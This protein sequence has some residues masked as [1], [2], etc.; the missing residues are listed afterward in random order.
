[1]KNKHFLLLILTLFA[2]NTNAQ[3]FT[4]RPV[5]CAME[6][7]WEITYGP[8]NAIW[9][10]EARGYRVSRINPQTGATNVLL[11]LTNSK[12]FPNYPTVSPQGGL[13]GLALHPNLLTGK[14]YVYLAYVYRYDGGAA[15]TGQFFKT[16]VVRYTYNA[17]AQ[18]LS[19]EEVMCDTIPGS[20]DH[21][22]GRMT[23]ANI[24][25]APYLFYGVGDMG[26]GQFDNANRLNK[27]QDATS[28]EGKILRFNVEPDAD[29]NA[30]EKWIPNDGGNAFGRA[31][32]SIGHRNPQGL[33]AGLNG[34]IYQAEHGPYSDDELNLLNG[35][36]RNYGH[37]LVV[38]TADGNYN[39]AAVG[40][41]TGVPLIANEINNAASLG[42]NYKNPLKSFFPVDNQTIRSIYQN[43][44]NGT[45]PVN[46]YFLSW[47]S[48]APSGIDYYN[49]TA[50]PN[51]Q[52][53]I[54]VTSLKRRRVYR[55]QL[56]AAGTAV[57]G[58]TIPLFA[59]MG[60]FRDVC[61]SPDGTKIYV[62]CD[63]EGQTSGPTAGTTIDP[64]NK[65]CILEFTYAPIVQNCVF[66]NC[67]TNQTFNI[68]SGTTQVVNWTAPTLSNCN[69]NTTI[70][71]NYASGNAFSVGTTTVTYT[72]TSGGVTV[73]TCSFSITV[74][75]AQTG[76]YCASKSTIP[77]NEWISN[78]SL[79]TL[80]N[81]SEKTRSD[82]YVVGYSDWTDKSTALS[83][84][85]NYPL[86][87]TPSLNYPTYPTNLFTR[88][89]IDFNQ[90]K[91][92]ED[93]EIVLSQNN[94]NQI[95]TQT[96]TVPASA[97]SGTTVMRVSMKAGAY[98]TACETFQNGE[99]EDYSVVIGASS[100]CIAPSVIC[101]DTTV[102]IAA[103]QTSATVNVANL[104]TL[105]TAANGCFIQA[106]SYYFAN[107]TQTTA[108]PT[109]PIGTTAVFRN[110][111]YQLA[112][113]AGSAAVCSSQVTVNQ[114]SASALPDLTLANLIVRDPSVQQGQTVNFTFDGKNIGTAN[115]SGNFTIKSYLSNDQF[116]DAND[117]QSGT[118]TTGGY[119]AGATITSILGSLMVPTT[120]TV[121]NYYVIVKIDADNTIT[122]SNESNN[123]LVSTNFIGVTP[124]IAAT[125]YCVSKGNAPWTEWIA[126]VQFA[127]INNVSE[128]EGYAN[129]TNLTANVV[130]GSS[131]PLTVTQGFSWVGDPSNQSQIGRVWIDFDKNNVFDASELVA[132]FTRNTTTASVLIPTTATIGTTRMR[133]SFKTIS[134]P[135]A[136]E[137]F[138][139]G[140]VED[141]SVAI[142]GGAA[143][144]NAQLKCPNDTTITIASTLNSFCGPVA[145]T[146]TIDLSNCS[147]STSNL[148][149]NQNGCFGIGTTPLT[150]TM[151][152]TS[153]GFSQCTQNVAVTKAITTGGS[154]IALSISATPSVYRQYTAHSYRITA[155]NSGTTAFTNVKIKFS[156]PNLTVNGGAKTASIGT[157]QDFCPLGVECSEWTIPTLS[158]G[159]TATLEVPIY[160]LN[161]TGTITATAT[162]IAST[163]TDINAANNTA[164]VSVNPSTAPIVAPLVVF[165]PTQLIPVVIQKIHPSLTDSY[166]ELAMESLIDK[167]I[168]L[169]IVNAIGQTVKTEQ[170]AIEKG[171]NKATFDVSS[172]PQGLYL[173]QLNVGKGR[174][175]PTKFVK[176]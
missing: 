128:K 9:A 47:N 129:F 95:A 60:R 65:G 118:I 106:N 114:T 55:L 151:N 100:G 23:I 71:S 11:D 37:P 84:G 1:V 5:K 93:A 171:F 80:N 141:Y 110:Y 139:K 103:N 31:V 127:N 166:I 169:N 144:C 25:G 105:T 170:V 126:G 167:P 174:N 36:G 40:F 102:T 14:P 20:S 150:W 28:Y 136:C 148:S 142:S 83:V 54:L 124:P 59:D 112:N 22:G 146:P 24:N 131:Y 152:F 64:P 82:R 41:G 85:A 74:N 15:I 66:N 72:A 97:L 76:V 90:N 6:M 121:G 101:R 176:M 46:N 145:G 50:I 96:L 104:S 43:Y 29:V 87:I 56:D 75:A 132:S 147:F 62:S 61:I 117:Y 26:A 168:E 119:N 120:L 68:T 27:A 175:V 133:V 134:F 163:P 12:N 92:F 107:G 44:V 45:I 137:V 140:E 162:L 143:T 58:D 81:T 38:G 122:E 52:N 158:A 8:D 108:T 77:W 21:N 4:M 111:T 2:L 153:G 89:W 63:S 3:N 17:T 30:F 88:V 125:S 109:L 161:P 48:I 165:K 113:G 155:L 156:R 13:M 34:N 33:V 98:P 70:S 149:N 159:A 130:R 164:S 7:P 57:V 160:V 154:D 157:F 91:T 53:S 99:V 123:V 94:I 49:S 10:T 116:L 135:T 42:A 69:A 51:W 79:N 73:A 86:S 32:Y 78:V 16:K 172:L 35:S 18:T 19:N 173:I 138:D 39:G 115:T 67:P